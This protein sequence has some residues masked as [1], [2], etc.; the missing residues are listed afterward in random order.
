MWESIENICLWRNE[1]GRKVM[2]K[3][4]EEKGVLVCFVRN[5]GKRYVEM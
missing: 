2:I 3:F 4:S 1:T 5:A